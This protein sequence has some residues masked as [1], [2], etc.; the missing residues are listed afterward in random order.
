MTDTYGLIAGISDVQYHADN[1]SLSS[2][3]AR[4]LLACPARFKWDL[5]NPS[6]TSSKALDFGK[7][8][9]TLI[10][11]EGGPIV[12]VEADNWLTKAAKAQ[13]EE[14]VAAGALPVLAA[15]MEAAVLMRD[16]VMRHDTAAALLQQ[17]TAELSGYWQ[18]EPTDIRLRFR[19][20]WMTTSLSG[21]VVCVDYKTT[22]NA[23]PS[24]FAASVA[25]FGYHQQQAWYEAGLA[26]HGIG[27]A[28]FLFICQEKTPPYPVS[29]IE[30]D[31]DAVRLGAVRN[32]DA[33]DLYARCL[34]TGIW[35][36][37]GDGISVV[38]LPRWAYTQ[39]RQS[40]NN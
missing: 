31:G 38:D 34:D 25:K 15:D 30:L 3:G 21:R 33:I 40:V 28:A 22:I 26:T 27:D 14:A 18:D 36:A 12:V 9:H 7:L 8:A 20:D 2:S 19:P 11:G 35:P 13:R 37:Y 32:R 16:A 5:D 1:N 24:D 23:N 17:G 39:Q 29:V 6:Q 4:K 10:L